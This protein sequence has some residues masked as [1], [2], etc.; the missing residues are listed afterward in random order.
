LLTQGTMKVLLAIGTRPEAI[1]MA[2]VYLALRDAGGMSVEVCLT[3]Q[4]RELLDKVI[5]LFGLPIHYDLNV[6]RSDQDI[7]SITASVLSGMRDTLRASRPNLL[8]VHGDTTTTFAASL[9]AYYEKVLVGHVEAGLRSFDKLRPF[10]EEINRRLADQLSDFFYAPTASAR[11][12]L[13]REG[14]DDS[15]ILIT[16]NTVVDALLEVASRSHT[17]ADPL[18]DRLGRERR[19]IVVTAHRRESFGD[20]FREMCIAMREIVEANPDVELVFPVHPNPNVRSA[21]AATLEGADRVFLTAPQDY[22]EF[23]HLMKKSYLI[24]TDSGGIQEE[25]PALGKPVVVM[26]EVTERTEGVDAGTAILAGTSRTAIRGA[27]QR[28]LDD[29]DEYGRMARAT[30]PYG[31]GKAA[32]RI[33]EHISRIA[34]G[35]AKSGVAVRTS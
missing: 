25:A 20:A 12:N 31:D 5:A 21:V 30:N 34:L 7:Y 6:M 28:L 11:E 18:L 1:K 27:V 10:P 16:G 9:A 22:F 19:L 23:V 35:S 17:F 13:R 29:P 24:L 2:P 3:A 15:R 26:R 32:E 14:F 33:A 8:L 4:H